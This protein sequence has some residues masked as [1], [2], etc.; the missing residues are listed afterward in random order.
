[1]IELFN[2]AQVYLGLSI[3]FALIAIGGVL[4]YN[5]LFQRRKRVPTWK[6]YDG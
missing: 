6:N 5:K 4:L 3:G 2:A 1:M